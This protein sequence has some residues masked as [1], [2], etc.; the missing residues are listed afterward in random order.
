MSTSRSKYPR[1]S[2]L[3]PKPHDFA[4]HFCI[5]TLQQMAQA[6]SLDSKLVRVQTYE[7]MEIYV[8]FS[9]SGTS[10]SSDLHSFGQ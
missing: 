3:T 1:N 6:A 8:C 9:N 7:S 4:C 2:W 10:N 5:L